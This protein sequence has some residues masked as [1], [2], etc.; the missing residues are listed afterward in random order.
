MKPSYLKTGL[1]TVATTALLFCST[2][3][4]A[5]QYYKWVDANGSTH[6]TTTPPPKGA[7][8]LNKVST[9][10]S[11]PSSDQKPASTSKQNSRDRAQE[12]AKAAQEIAEAAQAPSTPAASAPR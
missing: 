8:R 4:H 7:K 12:A 5:Q 10:G 11:Q 6:Y 3:N 2:Q 9:Y 1:Y